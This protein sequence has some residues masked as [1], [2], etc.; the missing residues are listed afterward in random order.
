MSNGKL[1]HTSAKAYLRS[2]QISH[3]RLWVFVEGELDKRVYD[4]ILDN[5]GSLGYIVQMA[6][7]VD[8][9][10]RTGKTALE[11]LHSWFQQ[12]QVL[13][14]SYEGKQTVVLFILDK[15]VDDIRN[16]SVRCQHVV[17]TEHYNLENYLFR[18]GDLCSVLAT[19]CSLDP[20]LV[21]KRIGTDPVEW[22]RRA[23]AHWQPW[24]EY[25]LL[26]A[27]LQ[28][29]QPPTTYGSHTSLMHD[30]AYSPLK[31]NEQKRLLNELRTRAGLTSQQFDLV[32]QTAQE[33]VRTAY[34][35]CQHDRFFNGKWYAKFLIEDVRAL[36]PPGR[37][38]PWDKVGHRLPEWL[39]LT[40]RGDDPW[41]HYFHTRITALAQAL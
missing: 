29:V 17:Y 9:F 4:K 16:R 15:D 2:M 26:A 20:T 31:S 1:S 5:H 30:G 32:V 35:Q 40:V 11:E 18:H 39:A 6:H 24:V 33:L 25:C 23:A 34:E 22:C 38:I 7:E 37:K 12:N 28:Q 19:L 27:T 21:R 3:F 13:A 36:A 41:T 10:S 14:S 8:F